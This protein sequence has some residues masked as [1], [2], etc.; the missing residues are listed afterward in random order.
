M[1]SK[2]SM[3]SSQRVVFTDENFAPE[4]I[5][6][7][8]KTGEVAQDPNEVVSIDLLCHDTCSV[9]GGA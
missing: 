8:K 9:F 6:A 3:A 2:V 1:N 4:N 7:S 5:E